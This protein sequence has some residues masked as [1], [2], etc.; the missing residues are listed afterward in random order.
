MHVPDNNQELCLSLETGKIEN[1]DL[2]LNHAIWHRRKIISNYET[3]KLSSKLNC[4]SLLFETVSNYVR[5][6]IF[7]ADR[8][9]KDNNSNIDIL[10]ID[11]DSLMIEFKKNQA[12]QYFQRFSDKSKFNYKVEVDIIKI[13]YNYC[14]QYHFY[15]SDNTH[16]LKVTGLRLSVYKP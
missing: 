4:S 10:R 2:F 3:A 11:T 1:I 9:I 16:V 6:E 12:H 7:Y 13:L 15:Q 8:F 5:R 14:K